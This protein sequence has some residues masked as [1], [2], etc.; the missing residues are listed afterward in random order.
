MFIDETAI[1][2]HNSMWNLHTLILNLQM[3]HLFLTPMTKITKT[4]TQ[5]PNSN[6]TNWYMYICPS[7]L[8][9]CSQSS[10]SQNYSRKPNTCPKNLPI[11]VLQMLENPQWSSRQAR[12][13]SMLHCMFGLSTVVNQHRWR[14][15]RYILP[16]GSTSREILIA[17]DVARS[18][19]AG[20][21]AK[22]IQLGCNKQCISNSDDSKWSW[23]KI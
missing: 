12:A 22:M 2:H 23:W 6:I 17:S 9:A 1:P 5:G 11:I 4:F 16:L 18:W 10:T 21:I 14:K 8:M 19:L 20:E 15:D 7:I 3:T 13:N